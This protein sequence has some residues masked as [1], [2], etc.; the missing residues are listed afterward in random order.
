M[1]NGRPRLLTLLAEAARALGEADVPF[2]EKEAELIVTHASGIGRTALYRD[3]PE[4]GAEV[5]RRI[6]EAV[7]RRVKREPLQYILGE[8][9]FMGLALKVGPGVLVPRPETELVVEAAAKLASGREG[10]RV[11][12]LCTGS[13]AVAL[14][15]ALELKAAAVYGTDISPRALAYARENA[16]M[17][18][19]A[20]ASF[21]EGRLFEP[22]SGMR[23]HIITA[24]PPYIKSGDIAGLDP[25]VRD[26]EPR[27][28]LDGGPDGL[29]FYR[30]MLASATEFIEPG[31]AVVLE[32]GMGQ[33]AAVVDIASRALPPHSVSVTNDFCGIERVVS[34]ALIG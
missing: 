19:I 26:W 30:E 29:L 22:V 18:G 9:E 13:G 20:N 31:G 8:V 11:L 17:N 6:E 28:A 7:S 24:N 16:R 25:E 3:A 10:V 34:L 33:A 14:A 32:V 23:F 2:A 21:L 12:D 15:L 5:A 1:E 4:A 27:E